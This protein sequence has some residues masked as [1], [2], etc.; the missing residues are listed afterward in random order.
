[1][2]YHWAIQTVGGGSEM[3]DH[4]RHCCHAGSC[5]IPVVKGLADLTPSEETENQSYVCMH[6]ITSALKILIFIP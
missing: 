2:P 1:M 5:V 6:S 3:A 4:P